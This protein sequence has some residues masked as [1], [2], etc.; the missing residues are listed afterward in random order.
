MVASRPTGV[1]RL[2]IAL[3]VLVV[4]AVVVVFVFPEW[5][6]GDAV[7]HAYGG[8][9]LLLL[10]LDACV[11]KRFFGHPGRVLSCDEAPIRFALYQVFCIV[12]TIILF[13]LAIH[14]LLKGGD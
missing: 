3:V 11:N 9:C 1:T 4:V 6:P 13:G 7:R 12:G 14:A 10:L 5:R 8:V 2:E